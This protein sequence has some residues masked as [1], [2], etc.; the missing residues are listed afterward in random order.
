MKL[1]PQGPQAIGHMTP[2][3]G[4]LCILGSAWVPEGPGLS[5]KATCSGQATSA[6]LSA[7]LL[8]RGV[9]GEMCLLLKSSWCWLLV[10]ATLL[11]RNDKD[12]LTRCAL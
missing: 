4:F 1:G 10:C 6:C 12:T 11:V 7:V 3:Q 2:P 5:G 9:C 8:H